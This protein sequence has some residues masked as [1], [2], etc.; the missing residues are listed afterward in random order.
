MKPEINKILNMVVTGTPVNRDTLR[1]VAREYNLPQGKTKSDLL[2]NVKEFAKGALSKPTVTVK[3]G[4]GRPKA[5]ET[6]VI[7]FKVKIGLRYPTEDGTLTTSMREGKLFR[8]ESECHIAIKQL[9]DQGLIK[10]WG[11]DVRAKILP[12]RGSVK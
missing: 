1:V 11:G 9:V 12:R 7:G 3:R 6:P 2:D 4:R 10:S 8:N 5:S